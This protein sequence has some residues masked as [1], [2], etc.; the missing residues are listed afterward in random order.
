MN[1]K[2]YVYKIVK[3]KKKK[4]NTHTH[5]FET[6]NFDLNYLHRFIDWVVLIFFA[7][8]DTL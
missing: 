8:D 3:Q 7:T 4:R 1:E 5:T 2:D 6:S